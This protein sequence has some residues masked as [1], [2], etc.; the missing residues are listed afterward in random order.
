MAFFMQKKFKEIGHFSQSSRLQ[1]GKIVISFNSEDPSILKKI[2]PYGLK[3]L[4][5]P[6]P[7]K[8]KEIQTLNKEQTNS[9]TSKFG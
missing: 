8:I 7:Y 4:E 1:A 3:N 5:I 2:A 9:V 6:S